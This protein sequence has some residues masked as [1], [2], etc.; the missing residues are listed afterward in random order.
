MQKYMLSSFYL[1]SHPTHTRTHNFGM[2]EGN[3]K[4]QQKKTANNKHKTQNIYRQTETK[5]I[6]KEF[7][8]IF[9]YRRL[10]RL[11]LRNFDSNFPCVILSSIFMNRSF[12]VLG[13]TLGACSFFFLLHLHRFFVSSLYWHSIDKNRSAVAKKV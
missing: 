9:A 8:W 11:A 12:V 1:L 4:Q 3:N 6:R 2:C 10:S 5:A 13:H 7:G